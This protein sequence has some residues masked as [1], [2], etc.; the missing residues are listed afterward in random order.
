MLQV[1]ILALPPPSRREGGRLREEDFVPSE[2]QDRA[3]GMP[4]ATQSSCKTDVAS[5]AGHGG[6]K[7]TAAARHNSTIHART[8]ATA[9]GNTV[10]IR[11]V[12]PRQ[13]Q[14]DRKPTHAILGVSKFE[15]PQLTHTPPRRDQGHRNN[16]NL[17]R[18]PSGERR[19]TVPPGRRR[20]SRP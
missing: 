14:A 20:P 5:S 16:T 10:E 15:P 17:P 1:S 2:R 7:T 8:A 9:A 6:G 18:A 4:G 19:A 3:G 12:R 11:I 13:N